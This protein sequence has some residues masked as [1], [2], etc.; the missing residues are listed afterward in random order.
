MMIAFKS[1]Y[2]KHICIS[3]IFFD[4]FAWLK[5]SPLLSGLEDTLYT[6]VY[7]VLIFHRTSRHFSNATTVTYFLNW[8]I[9]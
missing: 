3:D 4:T 2:E 8:K 6:F 5:V 7:V 1:V 9:K